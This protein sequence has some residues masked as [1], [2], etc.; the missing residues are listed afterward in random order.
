[1]G[2]SG[3]DATRGLACADSWYPAELLASCRGWAL[4]EGARWMRLAL[5]AHSANRAIV[6]RPNP[7]V[8]PSPA[9]L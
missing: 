2:A 5:R 9:T 1:V 6:A 8:R 3:V 4:G 7:L